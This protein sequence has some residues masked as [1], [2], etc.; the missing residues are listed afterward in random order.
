MQTQPLFS[1][2]PAHRP[3]SVPRGCLWAALLFTAL[4]AESAEGAIITAWPHNYRNVV[5]YAD[6]RAVKVVRDAAG[7]FIVA[8]S[9][10]I[11]G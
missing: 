4:L 11:T 3:A 1:E 8:G 5:N 2:L 10:S 7:D 6:D 9:T